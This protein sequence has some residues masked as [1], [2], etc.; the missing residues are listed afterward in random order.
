[1]RAEC[2]YSLFEMQND[3][4]VGDSCDVIG[5][6][7]VAFNNIARKE[8]LALNFFTSTVYKSLDMTIYK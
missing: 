1:M 7:A 4:A 6:W 2:N 8:I 3:M 5:I